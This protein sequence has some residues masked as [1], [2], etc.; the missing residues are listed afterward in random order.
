M[1]QV[2]SG[3]LTIDTDP[4]GEIR[5]YFARPD[6]R[7]SIPAWKALTPG[8]DLSELY[9]AI[10]F[11]GAS[12]A[13]LS[14]I[15]ATPLSPSM[16]GVEAHAQILE[17]ILSGVT[18]RRPD[19]GP[20]A[21][22]MATALLCAALVA[23]TWA[24]APQFAAL[25]FAAVVCADRRGQ[26]A[27]VC[28]RRA[29]H[30]SDLSRVFGRRGLFHRRLD[31]LCG[32]TSPGARSSRSL[33]QVRLARGCGAACGNAGRARARRLAARA[34]PAVLRHPVVHHDLGG[35]QRLG[36][37]AFPQPISDA[38]DR[39]HSR[40]GGHRRQVHGRRHRR[41]L[42]RAARRS[43]SREARGRSGAGDA[44]DARRSE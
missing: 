43:R 11:V 1:L 29:S 40:C 19:W 41:V 16:P 3:D 12:A 14:D 6:P 9:G 2:R 5:T 35:I 27:R 8:A 37:Y 7:R 36:A 18:L 22:W 17:Q 13:M 26:L 39:R 30:R 38:D 21:E 44:T 34:H 4:T 20:G 24:L 25:V 42:E 23:T 28:A 10:V 15:V 31:A 33:R 32:E